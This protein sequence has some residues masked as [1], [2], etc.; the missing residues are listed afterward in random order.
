MPI[1]YDS[2]VVPG[3]CRG[4]GTNTNWHINGDYPLCPKCMRELVCEVENLVERGFLN[5]DGGA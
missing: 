2:F 3:N 4:C 5:F 1:I